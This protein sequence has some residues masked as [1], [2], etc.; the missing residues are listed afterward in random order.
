MNPVAVSRFKPWFLAVR[1]K[2]LS[3]AIIP[4]LVATVLASRSVLYIDWTLSMFALV[5]SLFIQVGTNLINDALDFKKGADTEERLGPVRVTQMGWLKPQQ[6]L[7]GGFAC[8]FLAILFSLPLIAEGGIPLIIIA[9]LSVLCGY[10]YT[11]GPK[12][13]AYVGLGDLFVIL[14]F[15]LVSTV[16]MFYVLT[17]VLSFLPFVA[18][19]QLGMLC[20][21]MI[22][23]N[24]AR[25]RLEDTRSNKLTLAVRFGETFVKWEITLLIAFSYFLN[26]VWLANAF[27]A[28]ALLTLFALPLGIYV[29]MKVWST[30]PG[31]IYNKYLA[32][33]SLH[34]ILFGALFIAGLYL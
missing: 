5:A 13:L 33:S 14:F 18:G 2:T 15:G 8:F 25:D 11:G 34:Y 17:G 10:L 12:P 23:I 3:A 4:V 21:V 19:A 26:L 16:A 1:P 20:T 31:R 28:V 24:N 6:V 9:L 22:A 7:A 29:L 27:Y 30:K 32:L